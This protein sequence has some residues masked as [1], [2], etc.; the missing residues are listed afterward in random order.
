LRFALRVAEISENLHR[1]ELTVQERAAHIVEWI[2]LTEAKAAETNAAQLAPHKKGQQPGGIN[3]AA[4]ELGIERT[5]VNRAIK[6]DSIA[7]EA[8]GGGLDARVSDPYMMVHDPETVAPQ[9]TVPRLPREPLT[10]RREPV[11]R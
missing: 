4:R 1:A 8:K 6:I 7:P 2:R 3:A 10:V 11:C 9:D 5:E